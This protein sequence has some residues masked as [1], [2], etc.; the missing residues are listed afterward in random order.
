M[1]LASGR[2]ESARYVLFAFDADAFVDG[3]IRGDAAGTG[4]A[5]AIGTRRKR[6]HRRDDNKNF[7]H[8]VPTG[9]KEHLPF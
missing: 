1:N 9:M 7:E 6:Q 3:A 5:I 8:A 2:D 4:A